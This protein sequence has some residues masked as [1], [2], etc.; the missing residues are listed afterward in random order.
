MSKKVVRLAVIGFCCTVLFPFAAYAGS[1]LFQNLS[2]SDYQSALKDISSAWS[3][4]SVSPASTLGHIFGFEIGVV[5]G[6]ADTPKINS[7]SQSAGAGS[8]PEL[9]S[10]EI[11]GAITVPFGLTVEAEGLPKMTVAG[12]SANSEALA[13]KWTFSELLPMLPLDL[14][15]K[16]FYSNSGF[17]FDG[18]VS[19]VYTTFDLTD[20]M[21]GAEIEASKKFLFVE[22]Y[23]KLGM[24]QARGKMDVTGSTQVFSTGVMSDTE[25]VSG[26]EFMAGADLDFAVLRIGAEIGSVFGDTRAAAKLS[27]YF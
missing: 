18:T 15:A 2:T 26:T 19:G 20:E 24:L 4:T 6:G 27:L 5:A 25:T 17:N 12:V 21:T 1:P 14:D 9:P 23:V 3:Y 22:P 11:F 13:L 8:V 7:L 10:G 16:A